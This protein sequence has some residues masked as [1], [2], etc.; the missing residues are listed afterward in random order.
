MKARVVTEQTDDPMLKLDSQ[1]P[2]STPSQGSGRK[3]G[4]NKQTG[5]QLC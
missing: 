5:M 2:P 4:Q 1:R 3:M